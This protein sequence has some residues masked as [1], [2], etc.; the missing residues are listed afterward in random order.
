MKKTKIPEIS[1]ETKKRIKKI[2]RFH[3]GFKPK[4]DDIDWIDDML[5]GNYIT[6]HDDRIVRELATQNAISQLLKI[7][8][9]IGSLKFERI[10]LEKSMFRYLT[11]ASMCFRAGISEGTISLCRTAIESG[12]RERIAEEMAKKEK[13]GPEKL[14]EIIWMKME[15]LRDETLSQL[16][17]KA[18][19]ENIIKKQE[20][21]E[22]FDEFR[23]GD[24][25]SRRILDKF[26]HGDI[27]WMVDFARDRGRDM[28]VTGAKDKFQEYKIISESISSEIVIGILKASYKIAEILYY[29]N[30]Q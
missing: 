26:I 20:I 29:R 2:V 18:E 21:E 30:I 16:I 6:C 27:V 3:Y 28:R 23:L 4:D 14:P 15:E 5:R 24:Q 9:E 1:N 7:R 11:Y 8:D 13:K 12:L 25:S 10:W 22:I 19:D 17:L